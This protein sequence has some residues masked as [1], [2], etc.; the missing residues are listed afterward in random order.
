MMAT[1]VSTCLDGGKILVMWTP[2]RRGKG[3]SRTYAQMITLVETH[4]VSVV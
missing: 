3:L 2:A 1:F 4:K